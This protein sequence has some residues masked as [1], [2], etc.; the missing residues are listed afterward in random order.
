MDFRDELRVGEHT[1]SV[2]AGTSDCADQPASVAVEF[3]GADADGRIV[4]EGNLLM[5]VEGFADA[6]A[7]LTRTLDGAAAL[8]GVRP[9]G[10]NTARARSRPA[11]A[12]QPWT[13]ELD[14]RLRQRWMAAAETSGGE[15]L[16]ELAR[17]FARTRGSIRARVAYLGCDPDVPGRARTTADQP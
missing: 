13:E 4:A 12:G 17:D 6:V 2:R 9:T 8:H 14:E 7:F 11:N 1:Y 15:L 3:T 10:L 16:A 5:A